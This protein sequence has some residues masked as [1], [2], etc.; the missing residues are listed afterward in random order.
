VLS[1]RSK[2]YREENPERAKNR[3]LLRKYGISLK[4]YHDMYEK[5]GGICPICERK[6]EKLDVDHDHKKHIGDEGFIRE[7]LCRDCNRTLGQ[8]KED[9]DS[10]KRA[11]KY[12]EKHGK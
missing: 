8:W 9:V 3:D 2:K 11:I 4:D 1:Y 7:L 6:Y 12:L 10:I 5:Q